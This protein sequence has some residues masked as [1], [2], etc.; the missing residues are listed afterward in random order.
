MTALYTIFSGLWGVVV[1]DTFQFVVKMG[2]VIVL[3][4]LAVD[5]VG[6]LD[7]MVR[8]VAGPLRLLRGGVRRAPADRQGLAAA[9]RP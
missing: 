4:V 3:A 2:G 1:T 6:G 8:A 5:S 7:A 9:S